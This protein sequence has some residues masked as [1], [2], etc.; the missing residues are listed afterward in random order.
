[1]LHKHLNTGRTILKQSRI[2]YEFR[3]VRTRW[4]SNVLDTIWSHFWRWH[5]ANQQTIGSY[6]S[7]FAQ[8]GAALTTKKWAF[9]PF[10]FSVL[11]NSWK[12]S[13]TFFPTFRQIWTCAHLGRHTTP[14][15][16]QWHPVLVPLAPSASAWCSHGWNM[17]TKRT[18]KQQQKLA[19]LKFLKAIWCIYWICFTTL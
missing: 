12:N 6:E 17:W 8:I 4:Y 18:V 10:T 7:G 13:P 1:M 5:Q 19:I 11:G 15:P 16:S 3:G 9:L 14:P 2:I